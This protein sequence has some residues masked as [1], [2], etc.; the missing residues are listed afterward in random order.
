MNKYKTSSILL[1]LLFFTVGISCKNE[2]R[3]FPEMESFYQ[4]S[5]NLKN[6][7]EDS[8]ERF[9]AKMIAFTNK[10]HDAVEDE[11]YPYILENTY[12]ITKKYQDDRKELMKYLHWR[13]I[14]FGR[15]YKDAE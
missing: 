9:N 14:V 1:I 3:T 2:V 10:N 11:K 8:V 13:R 7:R 15:K 4:E 6:A 12:L 5:C